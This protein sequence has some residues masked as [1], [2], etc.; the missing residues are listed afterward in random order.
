M[1]ESLARRES[2]GAPIKFST[3]IGIALM[4]IRQ[5]SME[6]GLITDTGVG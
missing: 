3:D 5:I 4:D 6:I 2:Q 1:N